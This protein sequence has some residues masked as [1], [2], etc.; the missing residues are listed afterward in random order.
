MAKVAA[1]APTRVRPALAIFLVAFAGAAAWAIVTPVFDAP[2][3]Y[4]HFA[5][6]QYLAETGN[7][8][9]RGASDRPPW[10]AEESL[11]LD[12]ARPLSYIEIA[13]GRPRWLPEDQARYDR[14]HA[15]LD[16]SPANGGGNQSAATHGPLYYGM[17]VPAYYAASGGS[18]FTQITFMR[19]VTALLCA[20]VALAAYGVVRELLPRHRIAAVAAGLI[21]AFHPMLTFM[22]GAVNNDMGANAV[23]AVV[24]YL[25]IRGLRRGLTP[26]T[27]VALGAALV[28]LPLMKATGLVLYPAAAVALLGM[29]WRRHSRSALIAYAALAGAFAAVT[30]LWVLLAPTFDRSVFTTPGGNAPLASNG[31]GGSA[32]SNPGGYISYVWQVFFPRLPFMTDL[33]PQSWPAMDIYVKRGWAA[34]GWYTIMFQNWVYSVIAAAMIAVAGLCGV[35]LVRWRA[36]TRTRLI[37]VT[38]LVLVILGMIAGVHAAYYTPQGGRPVVA[39]QGRYAFLAMAALAPIA[40]GAALAFGRRWVAPIAAGLACAVMVLW[41]MSQAI[42]VRGFF[43]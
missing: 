7:G 12:E 41:V 24:V 36:V 6:A 9:A 20:V 32:L 22:G 31:V 18:I 35:A 17:L 33:H 4:D 2:D 21:V 3:E 39:E 15:Q 16:P 26:R 40:A 30:L 8:P 43:T 13:S 27:G 5:Y 29:I 28:A 38:V 37:E 25:L 1:G 11:A 14:R 23:A 10:S 34:F 42:A 19:L